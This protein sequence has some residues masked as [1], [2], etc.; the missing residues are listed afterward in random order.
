MYAIFRAPET[1]EI[2]ADVNA[3]PME[4]LIAAESAVGLVD[5]DA[6]EPEEA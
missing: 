2:L 1:L 6:Y 3:D 4:K 5:V